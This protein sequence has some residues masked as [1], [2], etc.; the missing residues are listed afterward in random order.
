[1]L[2]KMSKV[3]TNAICHTT[4]QENHNLKHGKRR[5]MDA[6]T[7]MTQMLEL[8]RRDLKS[9]EKLGSLSKET[10]GVKKN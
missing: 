4:N 8:S 9:A 7:K 1:M 3:E 6:N 2:P 5:S 10:E